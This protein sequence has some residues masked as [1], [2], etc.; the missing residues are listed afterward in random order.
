MCVRVWESKSENECMYVYMYERVSERVS[1][2]AYSVGMRSLA[3]YL[4]LSTLTDNTSH[5]L[6]HPLGLLACMFSHSYPATTC[7]TWQICVPVPTTRRVWIRTAEDF[8][9][10][11]GR[12]RSP[13]NPTTVDEYV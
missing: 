10:P 5:D 3:S 9:L 2:C 13:H 6:S 1:V 4:S 11:A 8:A 7:T 12:Y